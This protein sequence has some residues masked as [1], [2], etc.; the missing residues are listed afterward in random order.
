MKTSERNGETLMVRYN[1]IPGL[2][3]WAKMIK[4]A[5][6][7]ELMNRPDVV[8]FYVWDGN[9]EKL[10]K[11]LQKAMLDKKNSEKIK[12][13]LF[14]YTLLSDAETIVDLNFKEDL[15]NING[16]PVTFAWERIAKPEGDT[17]PTPDPRFKA[18]KMHYN[19]IGLGTAGMAR[20]GGKTIELLEFLP[21]T[22]D[23]FKN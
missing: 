1:R 22:L 9:F 6:L 8:S 18:G 14:E 17:T 12:R 5:G 7:E 19:G 23:I 11:E 4:I 3:N 20:N 16:K 10:P 2:E 15:K 13:F 21:G